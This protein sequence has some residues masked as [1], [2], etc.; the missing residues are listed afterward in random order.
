[1]VTHIRIIDSN[2]KDLT[3][4]NTGRNRTLCRST[5]ITDRDITMDD[6]K[7]EIKIG[8]WEFL[9]CEKCRAIAERMHNGGQVLEG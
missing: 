5:D 4:Y 3:W 7:D 1:M 2:H 8:K 6:A 9:Q